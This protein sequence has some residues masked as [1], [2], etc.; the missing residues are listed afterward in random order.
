MFADETFAL[1]QGVQPAEDN[2]WDDE[3]YDDDDDD[4]C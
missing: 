2:Q 4:E 1:L 3:D